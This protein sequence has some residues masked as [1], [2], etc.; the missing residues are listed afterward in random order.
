MLC[1]LTRENTREMDSDEFIR[2]FFDYI[3]IAGK[4]LTNLVDLNSFVGISPQHVCDKM[5]NVV[6]R[7]FIY[8]GFEF[9][10]HFLIAR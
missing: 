4:E 8:I 3:L 5:F 9:F 6:I 1:I 2:L 10:C 7:N